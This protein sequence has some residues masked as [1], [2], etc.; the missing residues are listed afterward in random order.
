MIYK[1]LFILSA[2]FLSCSVLAQ[3]AGG[4]PTSTPAPASGPTIKSKDDVSVPSYRISTT[5]IYGT[6][7]D[8]KGITGLATDIIID[9]KI[10]FTVLFEIEEGNKDYYI[11]QVWQAHNKA[12]A[13]KKTAFDAKYR[14]TTGTSYLKVQANILASNTTDFKLYSV[15]MQPVAGPLIIPVKLRMN[16]FEFTSDVSFGAAVGGSGRFSKY[17]DDNKYTLLLSGGI[18]S[19]TIDSLSTFA[20]VKEATDVPAFYSSIGLVVTLRNNFTIGIFGGMDLLSASSRNNWRYHAK[21][22]LGLGIGVSM[23]ELAG[24][25]EKKPDLKQKK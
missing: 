8:I 1:S 19:V 3:P 7:C 2:V 16:P 15:R 10:R 17:Q 21:P 6:P 23:F 22:W 13:T 25:D 12:D 11:I 20:M 5:A 14:G 4:A 9:A 18:S 24:K